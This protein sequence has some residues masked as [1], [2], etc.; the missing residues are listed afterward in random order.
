MFS[1]FVDC[2][3]VNNIKRKVEGGLCVG[4]ETK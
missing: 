1:K 3:G 4:I 2:F